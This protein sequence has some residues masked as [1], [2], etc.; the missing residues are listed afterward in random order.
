MKKIPGL[1]LL[2]LVLLQGACKKSN[3]TTL[4]ETKAHILYGGDPAVDG[5]GYYVQLDATGEDI[6]PINL[7]S[8]YRQPDINA[9]V[10]LKFLDTGKKQ[11]IDWASANAKIGRAH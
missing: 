4:S 5:R 7:P 3:D 11:M 6:I 9:A 2:T 10:A 1:L 8:A